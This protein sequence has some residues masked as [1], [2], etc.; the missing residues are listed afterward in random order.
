LETIFV[1]RRF[2]C[3]RRRRGVVFNAESCVD[4]LKAL[5]EG[6]HTE[7]DGNIGPFGDRREI[8]CDDVG[9][10]LKD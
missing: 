4:P 2:R 10:D 8:Q 7:T 5:V 6:S 9:A 3:D 1:L